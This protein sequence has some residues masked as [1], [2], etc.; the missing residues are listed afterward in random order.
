MFKA[1]QD[2][3][4]WSHGRQEGRTPLHYSAACR[5]EAA[6]AALLE[7]AGAARGARDAGG[8]TLAHYRA[9]RTQLALPAAADMP[10]RPTHNPAGECTALHLFL[11]NNF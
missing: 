11:T 10:A 4:W 6:V 1:K 9:A 3:K 8:R 2:E 7:G 5:D